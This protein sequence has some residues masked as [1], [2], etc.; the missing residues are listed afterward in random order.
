MRSNVERF[1]FQ[2]EW[3][4][5]VQGTAALGVTM[6]QAPLLQPNDTPAL[7]RTA[8]TWPSPCR[9]GGGCIPESHILRGRLRADSSPSQAMQPQFPHL[10]SGDNNGPTSSGLCLY[11]KAVPE[12]RSWV[13]GDAPRRQEESQ[14]EGRPASLEKTH[15]CLGGWST[16]RQLLFPLAES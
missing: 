15:S 4:K 9:G 14:R 11:L 16:S 6:A 12:T 7:S 13:Q 8:P 2:R 1:S 10:C 3:L 5:D